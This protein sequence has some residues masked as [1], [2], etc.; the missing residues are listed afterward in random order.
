MGGSQF[1]HNCAMSFHCIPYK[2]ECE[3]EFRLTGVLNVLFVIK[4]TA[5][6]G[7]FDYIIEYYKFREDN[8][9]PY[10]SDEEIFFYNNKNN[11]N[12]QEESSRTNNEEMIEINSNPR[13]ESSRTNLDFTKQQKKQNKVLGKR[14]NKDEV[15]TKM[16]QIQQNYQ[17]D[18]LNK[19]QRLEENDY[20]KDIDFETDKEEIEKELNKLLTE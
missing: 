12:P 14:K 2:E 10:N 6:E 19:K 15:D 16:L 4:I 9:N 1:Y 20:Q 3:E 8:L 13:E 5:I 17:K 7:R 18:L 11:F